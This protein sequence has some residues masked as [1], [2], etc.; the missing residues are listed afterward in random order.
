MTPT[1]TAVLILALAALAGPALAQPAPTTQSLG[2]TRGLAPSNSGAAATLP[3]TFDT[4]VTVRSAPALPPAPAGAVTGV[5][6]AE[7]ALR[8]IIG[9][10]QVGDLDESLFTPTLAGRLNGQMATFTPM[11]Q[12]YGELQ[13]IE[14][15]GAQ[16][17]QGQF[18]VI[19][20]ETA[21][22]WRIGLN[23]DGLITAL[24]F[25]E[26]PAES[27]EPPAPTLEPSGAQ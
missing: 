12:G 13:T 8:A 6:M 26:A 7:E 14:A 24:Q 5:Q 11:I 4:P 23:E 17:G 2:Q 22:Q 25:R 27:S 9:Q 18:L 19:F 1:R 20:A 10:I 3:N 16:S 21:T 15:Q